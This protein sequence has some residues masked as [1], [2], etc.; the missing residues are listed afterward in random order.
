MVVGVHTPEFD[1][2]KN[3][4]RLKRAIAQFK[5]DYPVYMDNQY[6]YW[7]SLGNHFWPSFYLVDRKGKIRLSG[8]GTVREN[9]D[10][11]RK[12]ETALKRL[13]AEPAS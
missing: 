6:L 10:M 12:F 3:R 9:S 4:D 8:Y 13:L 11:A 1:F 2:E 5:I 7:N